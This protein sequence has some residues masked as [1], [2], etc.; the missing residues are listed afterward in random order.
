MI[1]FMCLFALYINLN[2]Q[3]DAKLSAFIKDITKK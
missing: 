2:V 3:D 1:T